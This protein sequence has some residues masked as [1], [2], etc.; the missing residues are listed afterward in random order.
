M[1]RGLNN[2]GTTT[3]R[4]SVTK[5]AARIMTAKKVVLDTDKMGENNLREIRSIDKTIVLRKP[6]IKVQ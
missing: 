1:S 2:H 6:V 3:L 4:N 5:E